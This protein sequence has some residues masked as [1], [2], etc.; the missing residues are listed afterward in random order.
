MFNF[1]ILLHDCY[2]DDSQLYISFK[3]IDS[4]SKSEA[5]QRIECYRTES[6]TWMNANM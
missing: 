1:N 6:I 3:P 2:A 5:L 4:A